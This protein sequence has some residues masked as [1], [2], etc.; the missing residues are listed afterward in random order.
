MYNLTKNEQVAYDRVA[1]AFNVN[2]GNSISSTVLSTDYV[3]KQKQD[4]LPTFIV[5]AIIFDITCLQ[6]KIALERPRTKEDAEF[7]KYCGMIQ[8][9]FEAYPTVTPDELKTGKCYFVQYGGKYFRGIYIASSRDN[10]Y[11][12]FDFADFEVVRPIP[13]HHIRHFP[14]RKEICV[15]FMI[16]WVYTDNCNV[17]E[18]DRV[19]CT[20]SNTFEKTCFRNIHQVQ[21]Q[22][23]EN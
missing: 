14:K 6:W 4:D 9:I 7:F 19:N 1:T 17:K 12:L 11:G 23:I 16:V 21:L 5:K 3:S 22:K 18:M 2:N 15:P 20:F 10:L 13:F 8:N